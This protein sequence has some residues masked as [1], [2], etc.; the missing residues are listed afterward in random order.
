MLG[1]IPFST[2]RERSDICVGITFTLQFGHVY[3]MPPNF[4]G[5]IKRS[6]AGV[7]L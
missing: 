3:S 7:G 2:C 5:F 6:C 1:V 4:C